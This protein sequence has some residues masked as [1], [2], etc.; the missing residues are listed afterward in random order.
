M[1]AM[2]QERDKKRR[3]D[4]AVKDEEG[5]EEDVIPNPFRVAGST[6]IVVLLVGKKM[7]VAHVGDARAVLCR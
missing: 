6:A 3:E 5:R 7:F 4:P 1:I 2:Q